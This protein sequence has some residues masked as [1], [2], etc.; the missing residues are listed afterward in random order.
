[1]DNTYYQ[2]IDR[3]RRRHGSPLSIVAG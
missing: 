1:M 3:N 2:S